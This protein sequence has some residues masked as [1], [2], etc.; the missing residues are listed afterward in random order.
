[1]GEDTVF[2]I[3]HELNFCSCLGSTPAGSWERV[4]QTIGQG[5]A[6]TIRNV[7]PGK[8][9]KEVTVQVVKT[10]ITPQ[11]ATSTRVRE[12]KT[13]PLHPAGRLHIRR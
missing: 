9:R 8:G 4:F 11:L 13:E 1:M 2:V 6:S 5:K 10:G 7:H 3:P 12:A